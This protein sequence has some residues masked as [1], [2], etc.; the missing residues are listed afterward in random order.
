MGKKT[1]VDSDI[2]AGRSLL[3][4]LDETGFPVEAA[5]WLYRSD[6]EEWE[7][8]LATPLVERSPS[9]EYRSLRL[10]LE[11]VSSLGINLSDVSL[12]SSNAEIV[13]I[14]RS[15]RRYGLAKREQGFS[16]YF[17]GDYVEDAYV[18]RIS[19]PRRTA[20][21]RRVPARLR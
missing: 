9:N 4:V 13:K 17:R 1:L 20:R 11:K 16:G 6:R 15:A 12:R 8:V 18:Y 19:S 2:V 3:R 7:L 14:L 10:S 5:L 21:K